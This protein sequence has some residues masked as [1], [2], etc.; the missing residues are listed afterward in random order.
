MKESSRDFNIGIALIPIHPGVQGEG[1]A[2]ADKKK[3]PARYAGGGIRRLTMTYSHMGEP[4]T[5]IG[6]EW[7]HC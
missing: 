2:M 7:F 5:T 4:H 3:P 1:G 6:A